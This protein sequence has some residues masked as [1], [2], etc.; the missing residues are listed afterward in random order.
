MVL[1]K[2]YETSIKL[3]YRCITEAKSITLINKIERDNCYQYITFFHYKNRKVKK[4][5]TDPNTDSF[6]S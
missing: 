3:I 6:C 2:I 1:Y 4:W 5:I